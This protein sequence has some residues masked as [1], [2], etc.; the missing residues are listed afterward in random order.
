MVIIEFLLQALRL[1][2]G[3]KGRNEGSLASKIEQI[4][5]VSVSLRYIL[6]HSAP[7]TR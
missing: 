7:S 4:K 5:Q 6:H 1:S 3:I 2:G